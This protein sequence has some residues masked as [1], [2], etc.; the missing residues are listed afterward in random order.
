MSY[1]ISDEEQAL[2]I[3]NY[4]IESVITGNNTYSL[5][6]FKADVNQAQEEVEEL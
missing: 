5:K 4:L 1:E 6:N 3:L 2:R